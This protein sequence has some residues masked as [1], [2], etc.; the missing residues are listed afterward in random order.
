MVDPTAG[1]GH[2]VWNE[3]RHFTDCEAAGFLL[4]HPGKSKRRSKL[5]FETHRHYFPLTFA[6]LLPSRYN[7]HSSFSGYVLR[8]E[9]N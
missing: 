3:S 9:E 4:H 7:Q 8:K 6:A 5:Y 2:G 1:T